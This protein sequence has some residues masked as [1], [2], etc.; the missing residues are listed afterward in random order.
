MSKPNNMLTDSPIKSIL[1]FMIPF[2]LYSALQYSYPLIDSIIV[3]RYVSADALAAV[4]N[5]EPINNFFIGASIGLTGGFT[6]PVALAYGAKDSRRASHNA[7]NSIT[8]AL[9]FGIITAIGARIVS[10][11]ILR[12]IGTPENI[13]KLSSSYI[14]ILYL[15]IPLQMLANNFTAIAR[16]VGE[17]KRP[18]YY[19]CISIGVNFALDFLFIKHLHFGVQGAA[20]ANLI[21]H[22]VMLTLTGIYLFRSNHL[23]TIKF[24]DLKPKLST[25]IHQSKL[26]LLVS[27]QFSITSIGS[28]CIQRSINSFGSNVMAGI[29]AA[30]K[31]EQ[32]ANVPMQSLG[33][34]AQT[35]VGQNYGAGQYERI[36]KTMKKLF[37][38]I[39]AISLVMSL[40]V[41]FVGPIIVSWSVENPNSELIAASNKY[42]LAT[43]QCYSLVAILFLVRS[44]LQGMG[45][46]YSNTVA[47]TGEL[48]GRIIVAFILAPILGLTIVC[49]ASPV[50]WLC[51][52]IPICLI[53]LHKHKKFKKAASKQAA[54]LKA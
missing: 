49:Y 2:M 23:I 22:L 25:F 44:T 41:Y 31:F 33:G 42:L 32:L 19:Y 27:L 1:R 14:N 35:F 8:L 7:G 48:I 16:A 18:L 29:A 34:A 39:V 17:S 54:A 10:G 46:T 5:V 11:P 50:A 47:G 51:A 40:V 9:I 3:G 43:A 53:Y 30:A 26:G 6:I 37:V 28:M 15:S 38:I 4:G 13:I 36:T 45:F 12:L 21:A 20:L 52:D 24:S